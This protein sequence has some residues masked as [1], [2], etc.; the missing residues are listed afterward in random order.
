MSNLKSRGLLEDLSPGIYFVTGKGGVGKSF[1]GS[2]LGHNWAKN[3]GASVVRLSPEWGLSGPKLHNSFRNQQWDLHQNIEKFLEKSSKSFVAN[4]FN[5]GLKSLAHSS[6]FKSFVDAIP[7]F[8]EVSILGRLIHQWQQNPHQYIFVDSFS[9]GHFLQMLRTP[10]RFKDLPIGGAIKEDIE[11][12]VANL[13]SDDNLN[14]IAVLNPEFVI[15][16]ETKELIEE[17]RGFNSRCNIAFVA[18]KVFTESYQYK[19]SVLNSLSEYRRNM[20]EKVFGEFSSEIEL[21]IPELADLMS[22]SWDGVIDEVTRA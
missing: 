8:Y 12:V 18:N 10:M 6:V 13:L 19:S 16:Q 7:G 15:L 3:A 4:I 21:T 17:L 11:N 2:L 9:T 1:V 20:S 14:I 5:K 22:F